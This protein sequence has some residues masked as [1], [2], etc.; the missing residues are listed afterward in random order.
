ML[1]DLVEKAI[2]VSC[3]RRFQKVED[4]QTKKGQIGSVRPTSNTTAMSADFCGNFFVS[5]P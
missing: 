1:D 5:L 4:Q 3:R 2:T